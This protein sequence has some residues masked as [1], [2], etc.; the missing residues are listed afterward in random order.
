MSTK[1][2]V[3]L[4]SE[5]AYH[6]YRLELIEDCRQKLAEVEEALQEV[7]SHQ[8][9]RAIVMYFAKDSFERCVEIYD[10]SIVASKA[11][12]KYKAA[13]RII[14][15]LLLFIL[16]SNFTTGFVAWLLLRSTN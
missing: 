13:I 8:T 12:R 7:M 14:R 4:E 10:Y 2:P 11:L 3:D 16:I 1:P 15:V 6:K 9:L 5:F